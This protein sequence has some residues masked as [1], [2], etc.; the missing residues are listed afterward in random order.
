MCDLNEAAENLRAI[1]RM[2]EREFARIDVPKA[3]DVRPAADE[4]API[5]PSRKPVEALC[6]LLAL[7][8]PVAG[9]YL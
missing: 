6:A 9:F 1:E 7:L 4:L 3:P 5:P 2:V 8:V